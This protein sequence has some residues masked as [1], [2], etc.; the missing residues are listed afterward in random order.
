MHVTH[1]HIY[2]YLY[3][4]TYNSIKKR[5]F[6]RFYQDKDFSA[7]LTDRQVQAPYSQDPC[8]HKAPVSIPERQEPPEVAGM[9]K[10]FFGAWQGKK[11]M[12]V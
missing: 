2:I 4:C 8:S 5:R 3:I 6:Q 1:T 11:D 10:D 12:E 7:W 9:A